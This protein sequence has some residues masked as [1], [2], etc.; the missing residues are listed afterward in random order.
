[1]TALHR[2]TPALIAGAVVGALM[3]ASGPA[4]ATV[5][6]IGTEDPI[7]GFVGDLFAGKFGTPSPYIVASDGET[8]FDPFGAGFDTS[9][10]INFSAVPHVWTQDPGGVWDNI[11]FQTW[12]LPSSTSCGTENSNKCEPVGHFSSP[13]PWS[14]GAIGQWWILEG[15]LPG[16]DG[17]PIVLSDRIITSNKG[18][19][20][21]LTFFS[22]PTLTPEPATIA[23]LGVGLLGLGLVR[24]RRG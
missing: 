16:A 1:M 6:I 5:T 15:S 14:K 9:D 13:D 18:G 8:H 2:A 20:A 10:G 7:N 17:V 19:A 23:V 22:D 12:V 24:R 21:H 3:M 11:A 4:H